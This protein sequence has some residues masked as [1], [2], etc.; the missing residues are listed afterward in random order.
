[1]LF[2]SKERIHE[3]ALEIGAGG[4][5]Y[6]IVVENEVISKQLIERESFGKNITIIPNNKI[7][8]KSVSQDTVAFA[9]RIAKDMGG[10]ARPAYELIT[11][12]K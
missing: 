1:M 10:L 3:K 6:N 5:L 9:N 2:R 11:F 4:R 12:S 7:R 8:F